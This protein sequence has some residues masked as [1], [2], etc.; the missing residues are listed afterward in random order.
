MGARLRE[1]AAGRD[2]TTVRV[3]SIM[4]SDT[5]RGRLRAIH[6]ATPDGST[7]RTIGPASTRGNAIVEVS[8]HRGGEGMEHGESDRGVRSPPASC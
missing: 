8:S 5:T 4:A 1:R 2:S 6:T 7:R 3:L